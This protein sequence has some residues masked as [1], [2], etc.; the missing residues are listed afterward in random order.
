MW[1][2]GGQQGSGVDTA[3]NIYSRACCYGGLHVYGE[4]EYHSNIKGLHSYFSVRCSPREIGANLD[5]VDL[6][7]AFDSETVVRHIWEIS[8]KGGVII[9]DSIL[10]TRISDVRTLTPPFL[11]EFWGILEEKGAKADTVGD[12]L[13]EAKK[14]GVR[15]YPVPYTG[16]LKE[17]AE[18]LHEANLSRLTRMINVLNVGVTFGLVIYD[19][20]PI[21]KAIGSIFGGQPQVLS[22]NNAVL[23]KGYKYSSDNFS[24]GFG[25]KLEAQNVSEERIF[26]QGNQAVALGKLVGGCRLQTYYPITPA[27][28][29]SVYLEENEILDTNGNGE[30]SIIVMQTEDEIAAINMA[31]GA[32]LTGTRAATTTSGPGFSL[33]VEGL[34]WAGNNEVPV[35]ITYYQRG[36]PST[37]LPTRSGDSD[38]RFAMHASHG[39]FARIVVCSGDIEECF[40][41]AVRAFNYA[42][43]YQVPVIHLIDK[44]MAN[45]SMSYKIFDLGRLRI[46]RGQ[47]AS[48]SGNENYKRF[49]FTE[50]SISPRAF[51]GAPGTVFWNTGDEHDEL[52]HINEESTNRTRMYAKRIRKLELAEKE[53][54]LEERIG[55]YG[56]PDAPTTIVSWCSPKA[57]ILEAM[58]RLSRDGYETNFIQVRMPLPLARDY[59]MEKLSKAEKKIDVEG[60]YNAQLA[61]VIREETGQSMDYFVLKWN[62]RPMTV[63]EVYDA[64]KLIITDKAPRRQVLTHGS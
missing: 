8:P 61:G 14:I 19:R 5:Q 21:M 7:A 58:E 30:G 50:T 43:R 26:I 20:A 23:E 29:E 24:K 13:D 15:V 39:E 42:E 40:Y 56:N 16:I 34:G 2:G 53:I 32:A 4:R 35:V 49:K 60:N 1:M 22:M 41:D 9:D 31:S 12:L 3:A 63:G 37:G 46:E 45:S 27:A 33:M 62:G 59:I 11:D 38:L 55:F 44:A 57:A 17:A 18:E 52:G 48:E 25:F 54:P 64:L 51:L 6:L 28:D 10:G 36:A 47:L